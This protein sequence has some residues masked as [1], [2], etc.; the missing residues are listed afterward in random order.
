[1]QLVEGRR[2]GQPPRRS[3]LP[4]RAHAVARQPTR[5]AQQW[6]DAL[7]DV[8]PLHRA[9]LRGGQA[10]RRR[11]RAPTSRA[12]RRHRRMGPWRQSRRRR[13]RWPGRRWMVD[14]IRVQWRRAGHPAWG[15]AGGG[16]HGPGEMRC[17]Q[18]RRVD[19]AGAP[20]RT[21]WR[22]SERG[23]VSTR[24]RGEGARS[25]RSRTREVEGP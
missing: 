9:Q 13:G 4:T 12:T 20:G 18:R 25:T 15:R 11:S 19:A 17:R 21:G 1:M 16:S 14:H 2:G 10:N 5:Y 8:R 24:A 23:C 6:A 22:R 3:R 7:R